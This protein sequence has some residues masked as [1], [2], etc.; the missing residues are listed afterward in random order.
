MQ[1]QEAR[2]GEKEREKHKISGDN[3]SLSSLRYIPG[4][5]ILLATL[6]DHTAPFL[7]TAVIHLLV[8]GSKESNTD[9]Q[10]DIL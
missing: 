7:P 4:E 9:S 2:R 6:R 10:R 5:S 3:F 1:P 8:E